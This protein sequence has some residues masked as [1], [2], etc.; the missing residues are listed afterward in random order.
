MPTKAELCVKSEPIVTVYCTQMGTYKLQV[1]PALKLEYEPDL[2]I[3]GIYLFPGLF[4][5]LTKERGEANVNGE[6][7][8]V[9]LLFTFF[10]I[11]LSAGPTSQ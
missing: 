3:T 4:I 6:H 8:L 10:L 11:N 2:A 1:N 5:C 7:V 9:G